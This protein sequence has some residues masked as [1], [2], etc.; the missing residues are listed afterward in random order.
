M[1]CKRA[2]FRNQNEQQQPGQQGPGGWGGGDMNSGGPQGGPGMFNQQQQ[3]GGWNQGGGY[4]Q[5]Q[6]QQYNNY[7]KITLCGSDSKFTKQ[8]PL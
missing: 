1:E 6:P 3:P 4:G 5:G 8:L 7:G 2:E